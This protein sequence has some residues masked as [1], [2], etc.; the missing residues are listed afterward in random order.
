MG[1]LHE[2]PYTA[3]ISNAVPIASVCTWNNKKTLCTSICVDIII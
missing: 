2:D 3:A 1:N